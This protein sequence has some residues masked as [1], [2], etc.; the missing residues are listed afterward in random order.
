MAS[1]L[2]IGI[3][4]VETHRAAILEKLAA[5]NLAHLCRMCFAGGGR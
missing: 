1:Q 5:Q 3:R 2:G 4:T